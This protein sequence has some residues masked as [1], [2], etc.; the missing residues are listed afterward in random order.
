[1]KLKKIA[2]GSLAKF[3]G[4]FMTCVGLV[5]GTLYSV[6]GLIYDVAAT[7]SVNTGTALAFLALI[8]MPVLFGVAGYVAGAIGALVYNLIADHFGG[9]EVELEE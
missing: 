6:G 1:M 2:V 3:Q 4:V 9:I 7:G 5:A 8:G